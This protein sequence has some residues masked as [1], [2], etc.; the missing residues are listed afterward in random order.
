MFLT[1]EVCANL[2]LSAPKQSQAQRTLG[3]GS[4]STSDSRIARLAYV[5]MELEFMVMQLRDALTSRWI[6]MFQGMPNSPRA[7]VHIVL[8]QDKPRSIGCW[9][10]LVYLPGQSEGALREE[11]EWIFN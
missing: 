10:G 11:L 8:E 3:V 6:V 4:G 1:T 7:F 9:N 2:V 5:K